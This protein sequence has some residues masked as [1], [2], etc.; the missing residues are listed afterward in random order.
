MTMEGME[1]VW[2]FQLTLLN[3][4]AITQVVK[5]PIKMF[6][7]LLSAILDYTFKDWRIDH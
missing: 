5:D 7:T 6:I 2:G 3:I 1:Q 4:V